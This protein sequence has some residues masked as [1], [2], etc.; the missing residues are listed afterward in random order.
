MN[1]ELIDLNEHYSIISSWWEGHGTPVIPKELLSDVGFILKDGDEYIAAGWLFFMS[2]D[3]AQIGWTTTNPS[4]SI[5]KRHIGVDYILDALINAAYMNKRSY[6]ISFSNS[7]GLTKIMK[8]KGL[9]VSSK[10]D[11]LIGSL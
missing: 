11:F 5:K 3:L 6:I 8:K 10:H 9:A 7:S 2:K 4:V 1:F